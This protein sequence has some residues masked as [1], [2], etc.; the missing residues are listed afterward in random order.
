MPNKNTILICDDDKD[1]IFMLNQLLNPKG[2]TIQ[3]AGSG[4][5]AVQ[6]VKEFHENICLVLLDLN[7]PGMGVL[8]SVKQILLA[9]PKIPLIVQSVAGIL[10]KESEALS[11]K[12]YF[13]KPYPIEDLHDCIVGLLENNAV[14]IPSSTIVEEGIPKAKILLV[15][16]EEEICEYLQEELNQNTED[17]DY[18]VRFTT[19]GDEAFKISN[20]FEPD[21]MIVDMRMQYMWGDE[22]IR[23]F[24]DGEAYCPKDFLVFSSS[25]DVAS[26]LVSIR[27]GGFEVLN[28]MSGVEKL[29]EVLRAMCQ[30]HGL[31]K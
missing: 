3:T 30:K 9:Y 7:M 4:K 16:D 12:A 29:K 27:E 13:N 10:K 1:I 31:V 18:E 26:R 20:E 5:E 23:K 19:Q 11:V 2:Y 28:K 22:L 25:E 15:D 6:I 24:L 14:P 8:D 21:L 17:A